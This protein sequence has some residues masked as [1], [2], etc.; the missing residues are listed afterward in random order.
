VSRLYA[1]AGRRFL[2]RHPGQLALA[3][4][5]I[6]LGVAVVVGVDLASGSAR[7]AFELS[8][9]LVSGRA[10]HQLVGVNGTLPEH[11]YARLRRETPIDRA[12]PVIET[13]VRMAA[14]PDRTFTL[15][16]VDPFSESAVRDEVT[17]RADRID[18]ARLLTVPGTVVLPRP[19]AHALSADVGSRFALLAGTRETTVEVV[20]I[21]D[22]D[23]ARRDVA[24]NFLFADIATAQELTGL[25][26]RI[27]RIDLV[28]RG[29]EAAIVEALR[30]PGAL[31]LPADSQGSAIVEMTRAFR[32]NL[33]ALSLLALVVGTF[34]IYSTLTFLAVRRRQI[35]GTALALGLAR[36]QLFCVMLAEAMTLGAV[37]TAAGL[38]LGHLLGA[39]LT[40]LVLRTIEDL[41]FAGATAVRPDAWI[42]AKGGILGLAATALAAAAP[43]IAASRTP[44]RA[45]Q[46]R[47]QLERVTR[48][49]LP[50][51][52]G[53]GVI[54]AVAAAALLALDTQGVIAGFAG[55]F[56]V[57]A[58]AA[59]V[60]PGLTAWLL[61]ILQAPAGWM[62]GLPGRLAARG[63][64]ASLSRTAIAVTALALAV[65]TVVGIGVMIASFRGSV[66]AWLDDTLQSDFYLRLAPGV[67]P[68][69]SPLRPDALARL[70]AMPG[71]AGLS[72]SRW[73]R[74]PSESGSLQLRAIEPGPKGWGLSIV[75][76]DPE[77]ARA[78]FA[79]GHAVVVSESFA[80]SRR[81]G[82]GDAVTLP[83]LAGPVTLEIAGVFRDYSSDRGAVVMTLRA[84]RHYWQDSALTGV[85]VYLDHG[86]DAGRL[87]RALE[88]FAA[89]SGGLQLAARSELHA[90]SMR[91]FERTFT[92]TEVLRWLAGLVAFFGILSALLALEL[93]RT[94]EIGVLRTIGFTPGETHRLMVSQT[95]LLGLVAGLIAIPLGLTLAGLLV[96][97]INERAFGW[98]MEFEIPLRVLAGGLALATAA[99]L[100]AGVLPAFRLSRMPLAAALRDE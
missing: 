46:S 71:V 21:V 51:L 25:A 34:L 92:I 33:T 77:A 43:A 63:A 89:A 88:R 47:A 40:G 64:G 48:R 82:V 95:A 61:R 23:A 15:L 44:P 39:G 79:S 97:V 72:L 3:I 10:T 29:P 85:G 57:V 96:F 30:L 20:G 66:S 84:F 42:Y 41:Y 86:A 11:A 60:A 67:A 94:R 24:G 93:E 6:A 99:A 49:R 100:A 54:V 80:R 37:G 31:L 50:L 73:L 28:L 8:A 9:A 5:G 90:T 56:C 32:V 53:A 58:A 45:L 55:L 87:R 98:S 17:H 62:G 36:G 70:R 13:P 12:A 65:A 19:L 16:G 75:E 35:A 4:A 2:Q 22:V 52:A 59:L 69:A 14:L 91:I 81:L 68:Q 78:S 38:L 1:R 27:T 83:A 18:L 74:I 26:G 7:R 76:G